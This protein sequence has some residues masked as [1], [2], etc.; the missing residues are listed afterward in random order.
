MTHS[1]KTID[2]TDSHAGQR[3]DNFLFATLKGVPKTHIYRL[4]RSGQIRINRKRARPHTRLKEADTIRIPPVRTSQRSTAA[5]PRIPATAF[6]ILY[7]DDALIA[8]NKP[9]GIAVHGGSGISFGVIESIRATRPH[10]RYLELVHRLDKETSG[11]LLIA[12]KRSALLHTQEQFRSRSTGKFYL[13]GTTG[14]W[15]QRSMSRQTVI[16]LPLLRY[17]LPNG[18]R[19]VRVVSPDDPGGKRAISIVKGLAI[20]PLAKQSE[21]IPA[22]GADGAAADRGTAEAGSH[23]HAQH[24][25]SLLEVSIK[26][27][28]THQIRVHLAHHGFPIIGDEK[29]NRTTTG[30]HPNGM[31]LHAHRLHIMHPVTQQRLELLA[32]APERLRKQFPQ[33]DF[34]G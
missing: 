14:R 34:Q 21:A 33:H 4:I 15:P 6:D 28:R 13:A 1:V 5:T 32:P 9:A 23:S 16:D 8:I 7:E 24:C 11:I 22:A 29:Y 17:L 2:I 25:A 18:E 3:L 31:L 26:T 10:D 20:Q 12:R 27:G 19:R 30:K